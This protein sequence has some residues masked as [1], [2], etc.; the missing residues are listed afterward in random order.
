MSFFKCSNG[1]SIVS[2]FVLLGNWKLTDVRGGVN[3]KG[4]A[5][6]HKL[7]GGQAEIDRGK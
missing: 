3:E 2:T 6:L 4:T 1:G 7:T 5:L